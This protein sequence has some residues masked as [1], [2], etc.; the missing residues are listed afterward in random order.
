MRLFTGIEIPENIKDRLEMLIE[1]LRPTANLKWSPVYNLHITTKF[2]GEWPS[3]RLDEMAFALRDVTGTGPIECEV[4][5]LGWFPN[6]RNPRVFWAALECGPALGRTGRARRNPFWSGSASRVKVGRFRRIS[7]SRESSQPA[8]LQRIAGSGFAARRAAF[9]ELHGL[10]IPSVSQ[11]AGRERFRVHEAVRFPPAERM[12][13]SAGSLPCVHARRDSVRLPAGAPEDRAR[14]CA[15]SGSGN[16]G[17]TNVLRT[18]GR[19]LGVVDAAARHRE[20]VRRCLA[21]PRS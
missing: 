17:A 1:H 10:T 3:S 16:I 11:R 5:G 20:R 9:R 6:A 19:A 14:R 13:A 4:S 2:I 18:T 15:N 21:L 12:I 7:H 8:P